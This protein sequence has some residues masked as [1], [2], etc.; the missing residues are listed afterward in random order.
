M[1]KAISLLLASTAA[2]LAAAPALAQSAD[3]SEPQAAETA[4]GDDAPIVVT[5]RRRAEDV[6]RV[7]I[8]ITAISGEQLQNKGITNIEEVTKLTPGLAITVSPSGKVTP[9]IAI[10][11]QSRSTVGNGSPGVIVYLNDVP[12]SNSGSIVQTFD[13]DNV[14]VLKGPQGTLFGRNAIGGALLTN[15]KAPVYRV[16]GYARSEVAQ[17]DTYTFEGALNLPIIQDKV[18]LRVAGSYSHDGTDINGTVGDAYSISSPSAGVFVATPGAQILNPRMKPG[19]LRTTGARASLLIEPTD[20]IRNLTVFTYSKGQGI[21]APYGEAFYPNGFL[22]NGQNL[23]I[24]YKSQAEIIAQLAT[25]FGTT[26]ATN[27]AGIVQSLAQC[28]SLAVN[29]NIFTAINQLTGVAGPQRISFVSQDPALTFSEVKV[30]SNTTTI[31][32][33]ENHQ[34]K[35]IFGYTTVKT[36]SASSLSGVGIPIFIGANDTNMQQLTDELQLAGSFFGDQLK[37]TL[38]GFLFEEKPHGA[39]GFGALEQNAFFGLSHSLTSN[40]L[41]NKSRAIY[42]QFDYSL[43]RFIP[44]LTVTAGLRQTWDKQSTCTTTTSVSPFTVG[45]AL[46]IRS[47][48]DAATAYPTEAACIANS[49][50]AAG[51]GTLPAGVTSQFLPFREFKKLTYTLGANWQV[52][53]DAMVY[54]THRRGYRAGGYNTPLFDT[55][56]AGVQ[57]F[58]PETLTDWEVGTKL[59]F[60]SGGMRGALNVALF[61]GKDVGNQYPVSAS[62]LAAGTCVPSA[63]GTGG[64][65]ANCT[66]SASQMAFAVGTPGVTVRHSAGTTTTNSADLT[67][68]GFEADGMI[69]PV[70][71]LTLSGGVSY[72]QVKVDKFAIDPGLAALLIAAGR[73]LPAAGTAAL[74]QGQ[75][76]WTANADLTVEYP[77][78]VLGGQLSASL[79]YRYSGSFQQ[80]DVV[81]PK[82]E[83][84]DVRVNLQDIGNLGLSLSAWVKNVTNAR[85]YPGGAG[86]S[87][88]GL[89]NIG[90]LLGQPRQFGVSA[91]YRFGSR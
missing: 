60:R 77:G 25:A 40:Y 34:L 54:V 5:A 86:T 36:H 70:E 51:A 66:T 15:S 50:L 56:L 71:W 72:V 3:G 49:G 18:A 89:G 1:K 53:N 87:P 20:S 74:I 65:A 61:T 13:M 31:K 84:A 6:S 47:V 76:K 10:R 58:S 83:Y 21:P 16:E 28:S 68:R 81:I 64:R 48:N 27:Y 45:P 26:G 19:E 59:K 42:G 17:Y 57:S 14:Q 85:I 91:T 24:Y 52:T 39:G 79:T 9:F 37:Y 2:V 38:G 69:S 75:P 67:I 32:F 46:R 43:D 44:G 4:Q 30:L 22:N 41:H 78:D 63:I 80:T 88:G 62:N 73:P 55:S 33:A 29:C 90:L 23:A 82:T 35:N 8:S 11:G 12:L 7:P